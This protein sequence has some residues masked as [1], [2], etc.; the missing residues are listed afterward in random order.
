MD[1]DA[2]YLAEFYAYFREQ[3]GAKGLQDKFP[4]LFTS[5]DD[6]ASEPAPATFNDLGEQ[7][8]V[9]AV[10]DEDE[11]AAT[12]AVRGGVKVGSARARKKR[13]ITMIVDLT[14]FEEK[15]KQNLMKKCTSET[16]NA[17]LHT[18]RL[19]VH[20]ARGLQKPSSSHESRTQPKPSPVSESDLEALADTDKVMKH[21]DT[22]GSGTADKFL[23]VILS[24]LIVNERTPGFGDADDGRT[25]RLADLI[26]F[27]HKHQVN[28]KIAVSTSKKLSPAQRKSW[29]YWF[30]LLVMVQ[31]L[32][33]QVDEDRR[34]RGGRKISALELRNLLE[35][36]LMSLSVEHMPVR[37]FEMA[38]M[39]LTR[40]AQRAEDE[41]YL[42]KNWLHHDELLILGDD[43]ALR[44]KLK[45]V[46]N[47][48]KS[49]AQGGVLGSVT[50]S[51]TQECF[52]FFKA[53][54]D[55]FIRGLR[56]IAGDID[57]PLFFD[58]NHY[59]KT[60]ELRPMDEKQLSTMIGDVT[61][62][63]VGKRLGCRTRMLRT[64]FASHHASGLAG[65]ETDSEIYPAG[66]LSIPEVSL[67]MLHNDHTHDCYYVLAVP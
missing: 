67:A 39:W 65:N 58:L 62:R 66:G 17:K 12:K 28:A 9:S 34:R 27:Y 44:L 33:I 63:C 60:N 11:Q 61:A 48:H 29:V 15:L 40:G 25:S 14:T 26:K 30:K 50:L 53:S 45:L 59:L 13:A 46:Y 18:L 10:E 7:S 1:D 8:E 6:A 49:G 43:T 38:L 47:V 56:E 55:S 41:T 64:I 31:D 54:M 22:L 21:V 37:Y 3:V 19:A 23:G 24:A 36:G 51:P 42:T 32:R 52:G 20:L 57:I 35:L 4:G 16:A 2:P 5:D